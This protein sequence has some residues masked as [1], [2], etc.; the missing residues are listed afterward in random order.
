MVLLAKTGNI[1]CTLTTERRVRFAPGPF[2]QA[3]PSEEAAMSARRCRWVQFPPGLH[4]PALRTPARPVSIRLAVD[5]QKESRRVF[6]PPRTRRDPVRTDR[7]RSRAWVLPS[8]QERGFDSLHRFEECPIQM[9][10]RVVV[11]RA[12]SRHASRRRSRPGPPLG[13][14]VT[15]RNPLNRDGSG[16]RGA[17]ESS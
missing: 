1:I 6:F 2:S 16:E 17:R 15:G 14:R 8:R 3:H 13:R 9:G 4:R 10:T 5:N 12:G 11:L 7:C